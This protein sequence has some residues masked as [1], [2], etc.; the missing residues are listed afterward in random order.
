MK[1]LGFK[2]SLS[3]LDDASVT[4]LRTMAIG[5]AA[6]AG[7]SEYVSTPTK[8]I[9]CL[10]DVLNEGILPN[11][12]VGHLRSLF[13]KFIESGDDNVVPPDLVKI[14]LYVVSIPSFSLYH[15]KPVADQTLLKMG[16]AIK[17]G[18]QMEYE[19]VIKLY[20]SAKTPTLQVGS[21]FV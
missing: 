9:H 14:M 21:M 15:F 12:T 19:E 8:S 3:G 13:A 2:Y 11:R 10:P 17:H 4:Q 5:Q 20:E 7:D 18:G 16:Q 1:R 6:E